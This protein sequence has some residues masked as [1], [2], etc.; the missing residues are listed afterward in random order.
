MKKIAIALLACCALIQV[1]AAD[2]TW[3]TDLPRRRRRPKPKTSSS[4]WISRLRLVP[5]CIKLD[6]ETLSQPEFADYAK[7]NLVLVLLDFST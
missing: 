2:V 4:S 6:K 1:R 5:W 7:K 3:L